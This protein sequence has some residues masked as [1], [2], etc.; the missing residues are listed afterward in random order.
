MAG[1]GLRRGRPRGVGRGRVGRL[2]EL[3]SAAVESLVGLQIDDGEFA[4][5]IAPLEALIA[6]HPFRDRPRGLLMTALAN[7]GRRT[8][9]L[10]SFQD[11]RTYLIEETGTEPSPELVALDRAIASSTLPPQPV[12]RPAAASLGGPL[13]T[14][15]DN[16]VI[17]FTD[18]VD[19]TG[20]AS[21]LTPA[22]ADE[23]RR[24]HFAIL[25]QAVAD[26]GG[27]EV[28]SLGDGLMVVFGSTTAAMSCA[29]AM[30][31]GVERHN[32]GGD[33]SVGL[34]VGLSAGDVTKEE[35]DYFGAAVVEASRLCATSE[36]G[37]ILAAEVVRLM[38]RRSQHEIRR[39]RPVTTERSARPGRHGRDSLEGGRRSTHTPSRGAESTLDRRH[40]DESPRPALDIH[41][42]RTGACG[43][44][45][46]AGWPP[47]GHDHGVGRRG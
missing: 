46:V 35:G 41:R 5:A 30:Q 25:R 24:S 34:R 7:S 12:P 28:K 26:A 31:Q 9:T 42:T 8:D 47:V 18:M 37:Q 2:A 40:P 43:P 23:L 16:V 6:A 17:L 13:G 11:Y 19:S 32:S 38:G 14:T 1:P 44:G 29:V 20:L 39:L 45:R 4:A 33:H 3:R 10:R 15:T 27:T 36:G 22:S 21:R